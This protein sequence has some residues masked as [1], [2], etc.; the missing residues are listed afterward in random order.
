MIAANGN[1]RN[2]L[3]GRKTN[4][5]RNVTKQ[6]AYGIC[7]FPCINPGNIWNEPGICSDSRLQVLLRQMD[8]IVEDRLQW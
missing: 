4:K 2:Y 3:I 5:K 8:V 7:N 1:S 6:V